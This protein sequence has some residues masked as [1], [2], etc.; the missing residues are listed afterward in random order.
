MGTQLF[1]VFESVKNELS[2]AENGGV[3]KKISLVVLIVYEIAQNTPFWGQISEK[4]GARGFFFGIWAPKNF[5]IF[6]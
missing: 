5:F 6:L 2:G 1:G 3:G 4:R